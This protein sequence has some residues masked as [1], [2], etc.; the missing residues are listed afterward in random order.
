MRSSH[1]SS[2]TPAELDAR[3][4]A[5]ADALLP[6]VRARASTEP[7][8]QYLAPFTEFDDAG[9]SISARV[10]VFT[11][12]FL[13]RIVGDTFELPE[14]RDYATGLRDAGLVS[15]RWPGMEDSTGPEPPFE[16]ARSHLVSRLVEP[17]LDAINRAGSLEPDHRQL[18]DSHHRYIEAWASGGASVNILVPLHNFTCDQDDITIN[19]ALRLVKLTPAE[20]TTIWNSDPFIDEW[21]GKAEFSR[22]GAAL[23]ATY[24]PRRAPLAM[25]DNVTKMMS[26]MI[27]ALRL[28]KSGGVGASVVVQFT[29]P[30]STWREFGDTGPFAEHRT[31]RYDAPYHLTMAERPE[32]LKIYNALQ[33]MASSTGEGVLAVPLRR[34]NQ[35]Y[36]RDIAEDRIVDYTIALES[37]LLADLQDEFTYRLSLRGAALLASARDVQET[38][39]LLRAMYSVRSK[40]VHAGKTLSEKDVVREVAKVRPETK[41]EDFAQRCEEVVRD[42]LNTYVARIS[43]GEGLARIN[44]GLEATIL[45][46]MKK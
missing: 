9:Y 31:R 15:F 11:M 28:H 4:L 3:F 14:L 33:S 43:C 24:V 30:P 23:L 37:T 39:L 42:V 29:Q 20:K 18:L 40:I 27:T 5:F 25:L 1:E 41:P 35:A 7:P 22:S 6:R 45:A 17:V 38:S 2:G 34:F 26:R 44:A 10:K 19:E 46:G 12:F 8:S 16:H 13:M 36:E 21:I 32:C